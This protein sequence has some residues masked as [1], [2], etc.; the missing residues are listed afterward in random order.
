MSDW[1]DRAVDVAQGTHT[2]AILVCALGRASLGPRFSGKASIT[3][4]GFVM[5]DFVGRDGQFHPGALVGGVSELERNV[6]RLAEY[7]SLAEDARQ[8]LRRA[9]QAWIVNDYRSQPGLFR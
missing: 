6:L 7:L 4:D 2:G 8:E 1:Q 3:S 9:I 5:C